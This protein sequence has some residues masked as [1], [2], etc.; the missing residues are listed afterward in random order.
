MRLQEGSGRLLFS[1]SSSALFV[2]LAIAIAVYGYA[3]WEEAKQTGQMMVFGIYSS[4][5]TVA[6]S[7]VYY[8]S[9]PTIDKATGEVSSSIMFGAV[10]KNL[11]SYID[12][13]DKVHLFEL[14]AITNGLGMLAVFSSLAAAVV[15]VYAPEG[16]PEA[17]LARRLT[18][19]KRC[20]YSGAI[21]LAVA[22]FEIY[23]LYCWGMLA[24][25]EADALAEGPRSIALGSGIVFSA[26]LLAYWAPVALALDTAVK[27]R[28]DAARIDEHS[29][30]LEAYL[31]RLDVA[32]LPT[33]QWGQYFAIVSPILLGLL[34]TSL[35]K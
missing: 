32:A 3:I 23:A 10:G 15:L 27:R 29:L 21:L 11:L 5:A 1:A 20:L 24:S 14:T 4:I 9:R 28:F 33:Q 2:A 6:G 16:L 13:I 7:I 35:G 17:R 30:E 18:F 25:G 34:T 22:S 26:L 31:K 12:E 8:S 19:Y